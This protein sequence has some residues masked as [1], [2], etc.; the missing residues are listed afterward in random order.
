MLKVIGAG[1]GRTGTFTL[2]SALETLGFGPCFHM[3]ELFPR[4]QDLA[5][6]FV[7]AFR[8]ESINWDDVFDGFNSTVDW[9]S[10]AFYRQLMEFYPE[11]KVILTTRNPTSW[12]NSVVNT[13]GYREPGWVYTPPGPDDEPAAHMIDEVIWSGTFQQRFQEPEYAI[14]VMEQHNREVMATVPPDRL[15]VYQVTEG[16]GPLCRFLEV[17]VPE[18]DFPHLNDTTSF[19]REVLNIESEVAAGEAG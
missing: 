14:S 17:D 4:Q 13:I 1:L 9:P 10:C 19:R 8:G 2:K 18:E 3:F 7:A 5:P 11:S 12:H 6:K 16:W 15:L